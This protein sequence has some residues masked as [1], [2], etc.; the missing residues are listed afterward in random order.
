MPARTHQF[1]PSEIQSGSVLA[2]ND[3]CCRVNRVEDGVAFLTVLD[4]PITHA[5][6]FCAPVNDLAAHGWLLMKDVA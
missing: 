4:N 1:I 6:E 3:V 5:V 2:F